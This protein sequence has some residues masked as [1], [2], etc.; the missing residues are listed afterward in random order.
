MNISDLDANKVTVIIA[1]AAIASPVIT[2]LINVMLQVK[3]KHLDIFEKH[4]RDVYL[5]RRSVF[6]KYLFHVGHYAKDQVYDN[7]VDYGEAYAL[8]YAY[9]P[10]NVRAEMRIID[11]AVNACDYKTVDRHLS[12]VASLI[13][14]VIGVPYPRKHKYYYY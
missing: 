9:A 1:V 6:E 2:A 14:E 4:Y 3:L 12:I 8:A 13:A 5:Y 11:D 7:R 10:D